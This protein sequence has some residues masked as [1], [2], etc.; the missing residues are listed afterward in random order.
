MIILNC[1]LCKNHPL[2]KNKNKDMKLEMCINRSTSLQLGASTTLYVKLQ[3]ITFNFDLDHNFTM[4][5]ILVH[6]T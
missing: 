5:L 2:V 3:Y 4:C 1:E 6:Y